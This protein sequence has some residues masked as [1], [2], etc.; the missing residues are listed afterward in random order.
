MRIQGNKLYIGESPVLVVD[1]KTQKN[2]IHY[3][4]EDIPFKKEV[5]FSPDLP[6][7]KTIKCFKYSLKLLLPDCLRNCRRN[8]N[9]QTIWKKGEPH[10]CS[11]I[12][13]RRPDISIKNY[14]F[15]P[16]ASSR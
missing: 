5:R 6:A 12:T 11:Q 2:Y 1:L 8:A 7:W 16:L 4:N 9:C 14:P 13:G 15:F 3:E 10:G